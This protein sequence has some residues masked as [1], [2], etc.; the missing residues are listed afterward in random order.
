[1]QVPAKINLEAIATAL[2]KGGNKHFTT[3]TIPGLN[4]LFQECDTGA[5]AEYITIEQTFSPVVLDEI[6]RWIK[7]RIN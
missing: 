5:P 6:L 4:H 7:P 2:S 3:K 1:L